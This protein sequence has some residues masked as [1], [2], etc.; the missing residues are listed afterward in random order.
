MTRAAAENRNLKTVSSAL[1]QVLSPPQSQSS[2]EPV[3]DQVFTHRSSSAGSGLV[4]DKSAPTTDTGP[5][6]VRGRLCSVSVS[7]AGGA[8]NSLLYFLCDVT[9]A[10][11]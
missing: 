5:V 4:H 9:G 8:V 1:S 11:Q 7:P 3:D 2:D 6:S 10:D